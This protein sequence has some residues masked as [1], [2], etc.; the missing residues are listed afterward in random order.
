MLNVFYEDN[1]IIVVEKPPNVLSQGDKTGDE[2][3]L[4]L[5]KKYI[6]HKYNKPGEVYMG[7]V[8]RLDRQVGGIMVFARTSKAASRLCAQ[9]RNRSF[10]KNYIG[11]IHGVPKLLSGTLKNYLLKDNN[12][13]IVKSVPSST[14]GAKEAILHYK[15]LNI[16]GGLSRVIIKL[17]TGRPHQIRV[18][19]SIRGYPLYGDV[20]YGNTGDKGRIALWASALSFYHPTLKNRIT[21]KSMPPGNIYPWNMFSKEQTQGL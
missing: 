19:F 1:H 18:Q 15:V 2:D 17:V 10:E 12:K 3:M 5:V 20:K 11:V 6:K 14:A 4:C 7:L 13:N 9:V 16:A 21:F 8:H